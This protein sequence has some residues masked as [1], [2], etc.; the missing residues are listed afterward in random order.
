MRVSLNGIVSSDDDLEIY[1]WFNMKAFSPETIRNYI[2][3][4]PEG[5]ELVLE[6]NSPGGSVFAGGEMYTVLR[7]ASQNMYVRAEIQSLAASAASYLCLGCS[8]VLISPV[9]LM[10]VHMPTTATRGDKTAHQRS[11]GL[12][13]S[14]REAILNAYKGKAGAAS[15]RAEFRQMMSNETW[16]TAQQARDLGLVDGILYEETAIPENVM[17]LAAAGVRNQLVCQNCEG[18]M[19]I[20]TMR[21]EYRK[22]KAERKMIEGTVPLPKDWQAAA[23]LHL[24]RDRFHYHNIEGGYS[25]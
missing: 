20:E 22:A 16:L 13:D 7:D 10:M 18:P 12:L 17:D 4:N 21:A 3:D 2:K 11:I 1:E 19:D 15:N 24:E 5:E 8:E 14:V 6:I 25:R 23:R 9:G